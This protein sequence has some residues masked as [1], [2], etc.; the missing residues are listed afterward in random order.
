MSLNVTENVERVDVTKCYGECWE[1]RCH[2][3]LRIMLDGSMSLNVT[4]NVGR[5]DVTKC[6]VE[7]W[8][9]RCH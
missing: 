4:E 8:E 9:G 7:C 5:V 3:M 2:L 1:G 6:Y